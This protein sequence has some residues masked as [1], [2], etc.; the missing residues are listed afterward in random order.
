M[1]GYK[2]DVRM[3]ELLNIDGCAVNHKTGEI[4]CGWLIH[5]HKFCPH[6][7]EEVEEE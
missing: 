2:A 1:V 6:G 4:Y 5:G 7:C 3:R